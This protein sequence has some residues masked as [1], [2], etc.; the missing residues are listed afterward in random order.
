M[1]IR[2][3]FL[4]PAATAVM[5][6]V[7]AL[8]W[9]AMFYI[10]GPAVGLI[11][12]FVLTSCV[13]VLIGFG[14]SR[15]SITRESLTSYSA[16]IPIDRITRNPAEI[17]Q[18]LCTFVAARTGRGIIERYNLMAMLRH[19]S[20]QPVMILSGFTRE[21]DAVEVAAI[22]TGWLDAHRQTSA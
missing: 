20:H 7:L 4:R 9:G 13:A 3:R 22:I 1:Q 14:S 6:T 11:I 17:E 2:V 5:M 19:A 15:L 8:F 21:A 10:Q 16:P 18:I 12:V